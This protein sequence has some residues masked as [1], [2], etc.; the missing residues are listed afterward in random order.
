MTDRAISVVVPAHNEETVIGRL[1]TSLRD[2]S[3]DDEI[4][5]VCDGCTDRTAEV[6][7]SFAGVEVIEKARG[8]K[9]SAL[10]NGDRRATRF[11]RFFVDADIVVTATALHEVADLMIDGIEA[12]APSCEVDLRH[13]SWAVRR[14]YDVWTRLPYLTEGILGSG[15]IGLTER[16]RARFQEFPAVIDDDEFV[17]RL[18][19]IDERVHGTAGAFIVTPP[20]RIGPLIRIKTRSRLGIM[21]LDGL[22]GPASR[23]SGSPGRSAGRELLASPRLWPSIAVFVFIRIVVGSRAWWRC[24][25]GRFGGWARDD[26]SRVGA[27]GG[28]SRKPLAAASRMP[29]CRWRVACDAGR[30]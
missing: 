22:H 11:P 26:S 23:S 8:G 16:G 1:L 29:R 6:A 3:A 25:H 5:V 12:G 20:A 24:R 17:R 21:E 19:T 9:P 18:F 13:S 7:R 10:N 2:R 27:A 14:F 28:V 30:C 4:I 15:V